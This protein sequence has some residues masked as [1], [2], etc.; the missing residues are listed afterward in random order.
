MNGGHSK[1][2]VISCVLKVTIIL[3]VQ[4]V[5]TS[6]SE[7]RNQKTKTNWLQVAAWGIEQDGKALGLEAHVLGEASRLGRKLAL[8]L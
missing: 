1:I 2:L 3:Q 5:K 7:N 8:T 4:L 6:C